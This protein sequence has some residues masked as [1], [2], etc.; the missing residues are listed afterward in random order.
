MLR[1]TLSILLTAMIVACPCFCK[2]SGVGRDANCAEN[3][4]CCGCCHS[5]SSSHEADHSPAPSDH[6]RHGAP[7]CC[8][9]ICGGAVVDDGAHLDVVPD[10][11]FWV[12]VELA[13]PVFIDASVTSG[14]P[15]WTTP[16]P[17][18][19]ANVGRTLRCWYQSFL[20]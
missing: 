6:S 19:G 3:A 13:Q 5:N 8:Q 10:I 9:C 1:R 2:A 17:D 7:R 15:R 16:P 18:D 14:D 11:S 12:A 20:C 4:G